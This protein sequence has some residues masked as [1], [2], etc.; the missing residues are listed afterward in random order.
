MSNCQSGPVSNLGKRFSGEL[1]AKTKVPP[2]RR[3]MKTTTEATRKEI[4][5]P[6]EVAFISI[7]RANKNPQ[8]NTS[9]KP[10]PAT[11]TGF[12]EFPANSVT[13]KRAER[14]EQPTQRVSNVRARHFLVRTEREIQQSELIAAAPKTMTAARMSVPTIC[15]G[16]SRCVACSILRIR[17][18]CGSPQPAIPMKKA[19]GTNASGTTDSS[20]R[21]REMRGTSHPILLARYGAG[22]TVKAKTIDEARKLS[23]CCQRPRKAKYR[24]AKIV[25]STVKVPKRK[26]NLIGALDLR[27][28]TASLLFVDVVQ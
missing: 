10:R 25:P 26:A 16:I 4:E 23:P 21:R 3:A 8:T 12:S 28:S 22:S 11:K 1:F 14:S 27:V 18:S 24:L 7:A 13:Q 6:C 15:S 2:P 17:C 5:S 20:E 9:D 19:M